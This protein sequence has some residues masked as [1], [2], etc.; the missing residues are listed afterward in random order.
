MAT[1]DA[2][3]SSADDPSELGANEC[4]NG[5]D[6]DKDGKADWPADGSCDGYTGTTESDGCGP[7]VLGGKSL[8]PT[9]TARVPL[10]L[11]PD[12]RYLVFSSTR[13]GRGAIYFS[14]ASGAHQKRLTPSGGDDSTPAWS[15]WLE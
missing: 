9:Y 2:G 8:A 13:D 3:C 14:D 12:G 15:R 4:D 5:L 10:P 1:A 6:D 7:G 11:A